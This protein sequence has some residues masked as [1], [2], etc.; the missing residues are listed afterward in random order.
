MYR[1]QFWRLN[2]RQT[3]FTF[4]C[5]INVKYTIH[6]MLYS[7]QQT[8]YRHME[9]TFSFITSFQTHASSSSVGSEGGRGGWSEQEIFIP[10]IILSIFYSY[11]SCMG[12]NSWSEV[13]SMTE[14]SV[15]KFRVIFFLRSFSKLPFRLR[16]ILVKA[17]NRNKNESERQSQTKSRIDESETIECIETSS[18]IMMI[19]RTATQ[20]ISIWHRT[21]ITRS[22]HL[23]CVRIMM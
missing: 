2:F 19:L 6:T 20:F 3:N 13:D 22:C 15:D 4:L 23:I 14:N 12:L 1:L 5:V 18:L 7:H 8:L 11:Q 9:S 21:N 16:S 10:F 17:V